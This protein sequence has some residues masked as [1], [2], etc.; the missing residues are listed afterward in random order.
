MHW[1]ANRFPYS[2][3]GEYL[4]PTKSKQEKQDNPVLMSL[5]MAGELRPD[6]G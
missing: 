5:V 1:Q 3:I 2:V 4:Q 6:T